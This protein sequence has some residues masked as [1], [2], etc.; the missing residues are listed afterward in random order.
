[1]RK[2]CTFISLLLVLVFVLS[3]FSGCANT[4]DGENVQSEA[5]SNNAEKDNDKENSTENKENGEKS[6]QTSGLP[7]VDEPITLTYWTAMDGQALQIMESL[8]E[9]EVY[10]ELETR[11][12]IKMD[13]IHPP[14]GQ[15]TEQFNLMI[16]SG[17][18]LPDL[19]KIDSGGDYPGGPDKAI[20]DGVFLDLTELL[21]EY[22]PNVQK[23]MKSNE[24]I[25]RRLKT[26]K[27]RIWSFPRIHATEE[28]TWTGPIF[29]K[30][31]LDDIDKELPE[32]IDEWYDI[33]SAFKNELNIEAPFM[34]RPSSPGIDPHG[35]IV[36]AWDI[37]PNMY[38]RDGEIRYG[39]IEPNFKE[40]LQTMNKWYEEGLIDED[41]ATRDSKS[42]DAMAV[43]GQAGAWLGSWGE[44]FLNYIQLK[45]DDSKYALAGAVQPS[46]EKGE[47]VKYR[48]Q[49][50]LVG[51]QHT[52]ITKN[53]QY[54]E[55]A[56]RWFD[57]AYSEEGA[58]L[59]NWGIEGKAHEMVEGKPQ[60]TDFLLENPDGLPYF[61]IGWKWKVIRGSYLRDWAAQPLG[62]E[63]VEQATT[64]WSQADTDYVLPP[65][66]QTAEEDS[67]Y[68]SIMADVETYKDQMAIKFITGVEP[69]DKFDEY[70]D[71]IKKMNIDE[72]IKLRQAALERYYAR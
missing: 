51:G 38:V 27:G 68:S 5:E 65:I 8:E 57:Y 26:D 71:Q 60:F 37:G 55:E 44:Q 35:T 34:F 18:D 59:Y 54:V 69:I 42:Y 4:E 67:Q 64:L 3:I 50:E 21:D 10:K 45:K 9:N 32:T 72:A 63:S 46:L 43:G 47:K 39:P 53:C 52:V 36:S 49:D 61:V 31:F 28:P 22:A 11:T 1:M 16:S 41:F 62:D 40:Y 29:R 19:M 14:A 7:I 25:E 56:V 33:L 6:S 20:D 15:E 12:G 30:D 48:Q 58:F 66:T 70:V 24:E 23:I 13:F 17:D 2:R